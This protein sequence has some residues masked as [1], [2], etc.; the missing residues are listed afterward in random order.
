MNFNYSESLNLTV[1]LDNRTIGDRKQFNGTLE[2]YEF[3]QVAQ[4]TFLAVLFCLI[5]VGN[6]LVLATVIQERRNGKRLRMNFFVLHLALADLSMAAFYVLPDLIHRVTV[7]WH[8]TDGL[9]KLYKFMQVLSAYGSTYIIVSMS[10]DRL[11]AILCP[12]KFI[13]KDLSMAAFYV[14]PDL[15]H[16]VTVIWH[17]TDGLCKLYKFMQ[18]LSAYGSTYI[19]V[20]MSIDR[21][22]AILCP[23]K[24]ITKGRRAVILVVTAWVMA[25]I[26]ATPTLILFQEMELADGQMQ[27]ISTMF[28]DVYKA[29]VY[30]VL[31]ATAMLFIP[32]IL[33][34]CCYVL[35]GYKLWKK[36][37]GTTGNSFAFTDRSSKKV[38]HRRQFTAKKFLASP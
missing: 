11:D 1:T 20:S 29:Q 5:T 9:C 33:I 36:S 25:A 19:I 31:N 27:C 28:I 37:G 17:G 4:I 30:M 12:M 32:A 21:L 15:I 18:V 34:T 14:L 2:I 13:T 6:L 8:G 3:H 7:I 22:D 26:L 24:F 16:R 35:I 23:M 38:R 10:I